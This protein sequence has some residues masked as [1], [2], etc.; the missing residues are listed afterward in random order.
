MRH[1]AT[2]STIKLELQSSPRRQAASRPQTPIGVKRPR[3]RSNQLTGLSS[4]V[5]ALAFVHTRFM[6]GRMVPACLNSS[7]GA[8]LL[9]ITYDHM[10]RPLTTRLVRIPRGEF[11]PHE[12]LA[13]DLVRCLARLQ[14]FRLNTPIGIAFHRIRAARLRLHWSGRWARDPPSGGFRACSL[15]TCEFS[16]LPNPTKPRRTEE[17]PALLISSAGHGDGAV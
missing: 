8:L 7:L 4:A 12:H 5:K 16:Q 14:V 9:D 3:Q 11:L 15:R 2:E 10:Q 17:T 1:A 13:T 6:S